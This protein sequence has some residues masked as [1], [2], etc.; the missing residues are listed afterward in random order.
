MR[1]ASEQCGMLLLLH[2]YYDVLV[3]TTLHEPNLMA[4]HKECGKKKLMQYDDD[5]ERISG[6]FQPNTES[7][8]NNAVHSAE[9]K[10]EQKGKLGKEFGK[11]AERHCHRTKS[12]EF[13]VLLLPSLGQNYHKCKR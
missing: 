10:R 8:D 11:G 5:N 3:G 1:I 4:H 9:R 7:C 2:L 13:C 6:F 12:C